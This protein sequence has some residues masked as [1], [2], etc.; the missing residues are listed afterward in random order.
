VKVRIVKRTSVVQLPIAE[1]FQVFSGPR[2]VELMTPPAM[3]F[4]LMNPV[5]EPIKPGTVLVY[6][7]YIYRIPIRWRVRIESVE[8]PDSFAYVQERGPF[9]HWRHRQMFSASSQD[10]TE[11]RDRFEFV[12]PFGRVGEFAYQMFGRE[13]LRQLLDYRSQKMDMVMHLGGQRLAS[14]PAK[15]ERKRQP[16]GC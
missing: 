16:H 6:R 9:A 8:A 15:P 4:R 14:A 2:S 1:A 3:K 7:F 5:S 13:K 10:V 12:T 11:V